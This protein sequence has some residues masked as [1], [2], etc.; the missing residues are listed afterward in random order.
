MKTSFR[1]LT[2]MVAG[3]AIL[4]ACSSEPTAPP[5][6]PATSPHADLLGTV[7]GVLNA[8]QLTP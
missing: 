3:L 5:M 6:A 1:R 4:A 7:G 8:L 2:A